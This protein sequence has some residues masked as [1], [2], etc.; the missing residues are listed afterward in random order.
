MDERPPDS[1]SDLQQQHV[2]HCEGCASASSN[3]WRGWKAYRIDEP[4]S[5]ERAGILFFC[6]HCAVQVSPRQPRHSN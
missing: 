1:Q 2:V 3:T 5:G 4:Q 6:P